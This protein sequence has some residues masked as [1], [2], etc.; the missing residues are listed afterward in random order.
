[1]ANRASKPLAVNLLT[2]LVAKSEEEDNPTSYMNKASAL[3]QQHVRVIPYGEQTFWDERYEEN[4]RVHG[5]EYSSDWYIEP[6]KILSVLGLHIGENRGANILVVGCGNSRL[7]GVLYEHGYRN[8]VSIDTSNIVV[9]QMQQ[10]YV[11]NEGMEFMVGDVMNMDMFPDECYDTVIDKACIDAIFCSYK[12]LDNALLAY[13]ECYRVLK[14]GTGKLISVSSGTAITR[15]AH[16]KKFKWEI[17]YAPVA[18]TYGISMFVACK[19]PDTTSKVKMKALKYG[20]EMGRSDDNYRADVNTR[21]SN[22]TKNKSQISQL[23]LQGVTILTA[24]QELDLQLDPDQAFFFD[25]KKMK[26]DAAESEAMEAKAKIEQAKEDK[27]LKE[28]EKKSMEESK[29]GAPV[30]KSF[31]DVLKLQTDKKRGAGSKK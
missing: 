20:T 10:R 3:M 21:R 9:S 2:D 16:M 26:A 29:E 4:R 15:S 13:S 24:A 17:E 25:E 8:I 7:S 31:A 27:Q 11:M 22:Q 18:Y 30:G 12:S 28:E 6:G 1:M 23:S 14:P 5:S 19:Y